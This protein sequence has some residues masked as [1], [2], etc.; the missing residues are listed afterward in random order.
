MLDFAEIALAEKHRESMAYLKSALLGLTTYKAIDPVALSLTT[1]YRFN[2]NRKDGHFDY[3]PG[4]LFLLN[5]SIGFA[6][7]NRITLTAGTQWTR[8]RADKLNDTSQGIS[9]TATDVLLGAGYGIA[10]GNSLNFTVKT[11]VSGTS[12]AELRSSCL[13]AF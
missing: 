6:V 11:N 7:N 10:K 8:R 4:N 9:R 5:S 2:R 12:D 13:Y 1:A 3:R